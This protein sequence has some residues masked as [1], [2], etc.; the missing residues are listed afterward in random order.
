MDAQGFLTAI[1]NYIRPDQIE[2]TL[3]VILDRMI[4]DEPVSSGEGIIHHAEGVDL[5]PANIECPAWM[6]L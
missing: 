5:L 4:S 6:S 1:L 3:A 2:D